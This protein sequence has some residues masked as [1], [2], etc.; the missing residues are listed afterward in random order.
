[1]SPW[2]V[3]R[4]KIILSNSTEEVEQWERP[5]IPETKTPGSWGK[6][7]GIGESDERYERNILRKNDPMLFHCMLFQLISRGV[8]N[9][10]CGQPWFPAGYVLKASESHK[11]LVSQAFGAWY[12]PWFLCR[13]RLA[14]VPGELN[15]GD[16][17]RI[18][19]PAQDATGQVDLLVSSI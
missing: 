3:T 6:T 14:L 17:W 19:L 10:S 7:P 11:T 4:N 18:A 9:C 16:D 1:M 12:L 8:L 5:K 15:G 13:E 2:G